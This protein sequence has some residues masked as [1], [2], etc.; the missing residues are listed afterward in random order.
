MFVAAILLLLNVDDQSDLFALPYYLIDELNSQSFILIKCWRGLPVINCS[1]YVD[2]ADLFIYW[3]DIGYLIIS[4]H[5]ISSNQLDPGMRYL[6]LN[7]N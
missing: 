7:R 1:E 5:N 2:F 4:S 6:Q 3:V